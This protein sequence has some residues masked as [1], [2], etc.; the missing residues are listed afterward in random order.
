[1]IVQ[2]TLQC[3][4]LG[5]SLAHRGFAG[6]H[7]RFINNLVDKSQTLLLVQLAITG[8]HKFHSFIK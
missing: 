4:Q 1:M 3:I 8:N 7:R 2:G 6:S 5:V